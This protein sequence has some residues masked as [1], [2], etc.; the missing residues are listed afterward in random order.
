M[1]LLYPSDIGKYFSLYFITVVVAF[2][3]MFISATENCIF[4]RSKFLCQK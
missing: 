2:I 1:A 4:Y 3:S